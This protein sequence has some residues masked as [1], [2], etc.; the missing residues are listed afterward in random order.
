MNYRVLVIGI[1]LLVILHFLAQSKIDKEIIHTIVKQSVQLPENERLDFI[2]KKLADDYGI[3]TKPRFHIITAGYAYGFAA[4]LYVSLTKYLIIYGNS[5]PN[6]GH[7]GRY[8]MNIYDFIFRG[9]LKVATVD[10]VGGNVIMPG[11]YST[12]TY[13][14]A[15]LYSLVPDTWMIEYGHGFTL[16]A[17]PFLL[18]GIL[19]TGDVYG[20][21]SLLYDWAKAVGSSLIPDMVKKFFYKKS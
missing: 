6:G 1:L 10:T 12:L 16:S 7:S 5:L 4:I 19:S 9:T 15:N 2:L 17:L 14:S 8:L 11:N 3:T 20:Y 21:G 13:G 18:L